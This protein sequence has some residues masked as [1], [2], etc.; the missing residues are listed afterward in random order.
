MWKSSQK[1]AVSFVQNSKKSALYS[2]NAARYSMYHI[3]AACCSVLQFIAVC[4]SELQ[5]VHTEQIIELTFEKFYQAQQFL[6]EPITSGL[7]LV[8]IDMF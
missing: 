6:N 4:C 3:V 7:G 2:E 1:L 5:C 8:H